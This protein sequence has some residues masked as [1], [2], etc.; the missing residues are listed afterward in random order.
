VA[1]LALCIGEAATDF[2]ERHSPD[3]DDGPG[4]VA[5]KLDLTR[6]LCY[7]YRLWRR[8]VM[9]GWGCLA[10][11]VLH[12]AYKRC[13]LKYWSRHKTKDGKSRYNLTDDRHDDTTLQTKDKE[14]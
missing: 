6:R 4:S 13:T 1:D 9:D 2:I 3:L 7:E 14:Q 10:C 12:K 11:E 8:N 5:A